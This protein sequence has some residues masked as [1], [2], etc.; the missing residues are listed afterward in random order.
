MRLALLLI[1][2]SLLSGAEDQLAAVRTG[3]QQLAIDPSQTYRV[4][5][6]ELNEGGAKFY[7][8]EGVLAFATPVDGQRIAAVFTTASS[9]AG[10][11][12]VIVLPPIAAER[13]SLARFTKTPNLDEHFSSA[14]LFFSNGTA[15]ELLRQI[16]AR[17]VHPAPELG[18]DIAASFG[19]IL[20]KSAAEIEVRIARSILDAHAPVNGYFYGILA[21]RSLGAVDF[22]YQPDEPDTVIL[23]RLAT[24]S[25][26]TTG[27]TESYFQ[28]WSAFRPKSFK[29][30]MPGYHV[31]QY[32]I[33]TTIRP[34]LS[35]NATAEFNYQADADDG[36]TISLLL[37][38]RLRV[39][40]A[41]ID[42]DSASVL[43]HDSPRDAD[44]HGAMNFL[45]VNRQVMAPQSHHHV[46]LQYE[47]SVVRRTAK[48]AYF[49]DDRNAWYPFLLP[50]LTNFDLT[51]HLPANLQLMATG[52]P[53]R[54]QEVSAQ[55]VHRR[56]ASPQALAGFNVGEFEVRQAEDPPYKIEIC[57]NPHEAVPP[58]L[59]EQAAQILRYF[60][61]R[62]MPLS[63]R[64]LSIT[65]IEGYFGQ[66]F[67]GLIY[68]SDISYL[69]EKD[70][71]G[72]LRNASLDTFFSRLL[73]PHE[74]AH[75]WWGNVVTPS[76]YRSNWIVEA[77]ANYSALQYLEQTQGPKI[78][79]EILAEYRA[80]LMHVRKT[81]ELVDSYG[82]VTFDQRLANNFGEG[83]WHDILYEKGTWIFHM[84]RR[85]M[86]ENRFHGFQQ[87]LLAEFSRQPI[88]NENL[89]ARAMEFLPAGQS[90]KNLTSFFDTWVYDTG[91]PVL[92][93]HSNQLELSDVPDSYVL[94]V[95]LTC[96][97]REQWIR[98]NSG[99]IPLPNPNCSLP[100][101]SDF[102]Y[103]SK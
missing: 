7:L 38:P 20:Q 86:G 74:I 8:A 80:D 29:E 30:T 60:S 69:Q 16:H 89:R 52:D 40:A 76:D 101:V 65:P 79:N 96:G 85:R 75:Q 93:I 59:N 22:I 15:E 62:W 97:N 68:L 92:S 37:T 9:E 94:D 54:D 58:N 3:L 51:F 2:A 72:N 19:S 95:P 50:M 14:L 26:V 28:I 17:P 98:V 45:L 77:M 83:I 91:I 43:M 102:L 47:G 44:L 87:K 55:T 103:R 73:L 78:I 6:L 66:G 53:V 12:E 24:R 48:G 21:G 35:M 31:S 63:A 64:N 70:R 25:A 32:R 11:A 5:E 57:S 49:V 100:S 99:A 1:C 13:A 33:E 84:L 10:D 41:T 56:T 46:R 4:R 39:T 90:D 23:G 42:G 36:A 82:P 18:I 61:E 34:D 88:S 71:P 27:L 81:G 67:P